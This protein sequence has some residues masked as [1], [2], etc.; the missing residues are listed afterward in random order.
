MKSQKTRM[1]IAII[2]LV[3]IISCI[4]G[5]A[6]LSEKDTLTD[7]KTVT[8]GSE[9][10]HNAPSAFDQ[11]SDVDDTTDSHIESDLEII[12]RT[13]HPTYYGSIES[14][15]ALWDDVASGKIVFGNGYNEYSDKTILC[16]EGYRNSDLIHGIEV[17]FSNFEQPATISLEEALPIITSYIPYD[18]IEKYYQFNE[19]KVYIPDEDNSAQTK[20]YVITYNLT[21]NGK[22]LYGNE[23]EYSGSIDIVINVNENESV[24]SFSINFGV[25]R[26]M[27]SPS[28]NNY[29]IEKWEY[30]LNDF[31]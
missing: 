18:V 2:L 10:A 6:S 22:A 29:H 27:M 15:H 24:D 7:T 31:N 28:T 26:W 1:I 11:S 21:D 23:H 30:N 8:K 25:P 3:V 4:Y 12:T 13:G 19:S 20:Y 9:Q 17:Y 16:V 5:I 14:S